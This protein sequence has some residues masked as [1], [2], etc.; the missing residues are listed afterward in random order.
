[1]GYVVEMYKNR[2][3][4]KG[5]ILSSG[6]IESAT[7]RAGNF[8]ERYPDRDIRLIETL[9]S[10]AEVCRGVW[11]RTVLNERIDS[12]KEQYNQS[13]L[14]KG[15]MLY[16]IEAARVDREA[17]SLVM[18][19]RRKE[20][21]KDWIARLKIQWPNMLAEIIDPL[22]LVAETYVKGDYI[23]NLPEDEVPKLVVK[24]VT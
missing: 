12:L 4:I 5:Q 2:R 18:E 24:V 16:A 1:M 19:T 9:P 23:Q 22:G 20:D 14:P 10:G 21:A 17:E 13:T 11:D 6:G 15:Y 7:K 8:A 3:Y